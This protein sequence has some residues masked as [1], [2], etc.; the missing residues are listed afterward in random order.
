MK[1][2]YTDQA[3][4]DLDGILQFIAAEFPVAYAG[5]EQRLRL[6]EARIGQWPDSGQRVAQRPGVRV[7]PMVRYPYRVFY[8][9]GQDGVEVLHIH[10]TARV[11]P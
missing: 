7:V 3:L 1:V 4:R 9:I 6:I 2:S 11:G 8:Q 10:H 5:F